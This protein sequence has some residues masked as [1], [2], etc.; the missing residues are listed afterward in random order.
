MALDSAARE[1][2]IYAVIKALAGGAASTIGS[3]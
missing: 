2:A 3:L 1:S